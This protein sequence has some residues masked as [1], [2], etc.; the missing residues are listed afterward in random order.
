LRAGGCLVVFGDAVEER[1]E[2]GGGEF[3]VEGPCGLVVAVHEREQGA[4]E[5][6]KAGE[7][8]GGDDFLLDDGEEDYLEPGSLW[9]R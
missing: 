9:S 2:V 3:P 4:A 7:V 8:V 5:L 6:V 1:G